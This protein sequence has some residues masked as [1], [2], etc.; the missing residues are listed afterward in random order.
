MASSETTSTAS[1][2]GGE[3]VLG[4]G[5]KPLRLLNAFLEEGGIKTI[6]HPQLKR[7]KC[8]DRTKR[9]YIQHTTDIL[10]AVLKVVSPENA[11]YLW[12]ALQASKVVNDEL[13]VEGILHPSQRVYL[14]AIAETYKNASSWDTRRQILSVMTG[15]AS[16]ASIQEYIPGLSQYRYT[17]ANLHRLQH[18]IGTPVPN[19]PAARLRVDETQLDHFLQFITSPHIVQD[20]PFGEKCLRLSNGN[21]LEV[22]N[23]IRALIPERITSQYKQ[24]CQEVGFIPFSQRTMLRI[25]SACSA[26]VRKSLQGLDYVAAD[27]A[28][29]F[30]D[31]ANLLHQYSHLVT[32][33]TLERWQRTLKNGKLYL[34]GDFKVNKALS[35]EKMFG[36]TFCWRFDDKETSLAFSLRRAKNIYRG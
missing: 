18:G 7:N 33:A 17:V 23:V 22:P 10:V 34:K 13:G 6:S 36:E 16:L 9:R 14:E 2:L 19:Q 8:A 4:G 27:G 35:D 12:S 32:V 20:L 26:T 29:A 28:S 5:S 30:D 1:S 31:L 3:V 24:Y 11:G 21:V 25:L 15:T